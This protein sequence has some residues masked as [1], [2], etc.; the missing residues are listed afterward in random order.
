MSDSET[1][2]VGQGVKTNPISSGENGRVSRRKARTDVKMPQCQGT[3][4]D[5]GACPF[6]AKT[7]LRMCGKHM[8]QAEPEAPRTCIHIKVSGG[9]C[10]KV[11]VSGGHRCAYHVRI[12]QRRQE[13]NA[14]RVVWY[15]A[16]DM[17]WTYSDPEGAQLVVR[18]AFE[19]G[20]LTERW[21]DIVMG[22]LGIDLAAWHALHRLPENVE[23]KGDLHK[24]V[25]DSQN[26][27][28]TVVANQTTEAL[29]KLLDVEVSPEQDTLREIAHAWQGYPEK[30][31]KLVL[32]DIRR[33]YDTA[34]CREENDALYR[35]V[36][37]GLWA[38]IKDNEELINRLWEEAVDSKGMCC[39]G[40]LSRL[41][42][43][44]V[45]FDDEFQPQISK[46]ELLQQ[47][48]A[49][50]ANQDTD[51]LDK[52]EQAWSVFEELEIPMHE[53]DAWIEAF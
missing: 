31:R 4:K 28:T 1:C 41:S 52:V 25:L 2:G 23:L 38:R 29:N 27:H 42:N 36:L 34:M 51:V 32:R 26:V 24:L 6:K 7:G 37:D 39:E 49:A 40:H 53:R 3:C 47:K 44:L 12:E 22:E 18:E 17:L 35:R 45:G 9:M 5:G 8:S 21:Y 11:A 20:I 13:Q 33:W 16:M 30:Q 14:S 46:G 48:I 10:G 43:V 19:S 15:S 50:I